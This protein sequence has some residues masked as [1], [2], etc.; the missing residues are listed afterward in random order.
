MKDKIFTFIVGLLVGAIITTGIF[1]IINKNKSNDTNIQ[2]QTYT[3]RQIPDELK[4]GPGKEGE[5]PPERPEENSDGEEREEP[6]A[7]PDGN[8]SEQKS[9][10][11]K[12]QT[13]E[14]SS[15]STNN[16]SI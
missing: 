9:K 6:P 14:K 3:E 5:T 7:K 10:A 15:D 11:S 8:S 13:T 12:N 1:L 4:E 2:N 16:N